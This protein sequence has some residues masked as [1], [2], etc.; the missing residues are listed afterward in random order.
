MRKTGCCALPVGSTQLK[1]K[2]QAC[3]QFGVGGFSWKNDDET[4]KFTF[5]STTIMRMNEVENQFTTATKR[6]NI[7]S[8]GMKSLDNSNNSL[9]AN[10]TILQKSTARQA[11]S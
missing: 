8:L 6:K 1:I 9:S 3:S 5:P 11:N 7:T 4:D 2:A 10:W